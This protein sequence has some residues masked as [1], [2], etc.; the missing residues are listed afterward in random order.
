[1]S[2]RSL[3]AAAAVLLTVLCAMGQAHAC[4]TT[5]DC[6]PPYGMWRC[7]CRRLWHAC[8][9]LTDLL[10]CAVLCCAPCVGMCDPNNRC[11]CAGLRYESDGTASA[12][13]AVSTCAMHMLEVDPPTGRM[14]MGFVA[15]FA[16]CELTA[17]A[18]ATA[19]LFYR[20]RARLSLQT[21]SLFALLIGA[22]VRFCGSAAIAGHA[23]EPWRTS[24]RLD[25][26]LN[27]LPDTIGV[28]IWAGVGPFL[29]DLASNI[30][31]V[32]PKRRYIATAIGVALDL[33][34]Y[35]ALNLLGP[36]Y[37]FP[38]AYGTT[39]RSAVLWLCCVVLY[40]RTDCVVALPHC[41]CA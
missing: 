16:G 11:L 29:S 18:L 2:I 17:T 19:L 13:A 12:K 33:L 7:R 24:D 15:A 3:A 23:Y 22:L 27:F 20:R 36:F 34:N 1:M 14:M 4:N 39:T 30:L 6:H 9:L 10:R 35:L 21:Y 41:L 25:Y 38:F 26:L 32:D 37:L 31:Q 40:R 5:D 8:W 28:T